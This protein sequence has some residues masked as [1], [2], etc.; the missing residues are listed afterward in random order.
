MD[1]SQA[2]TAEDFPEWVSQEFMRLNPDVE[3]VYEVITNAGASEKISAAILARQTP[4]LMKDVV[5]RKEWAE[6][7]LLEPIDDY[8]DP[9]DWEDWYELTLAKGRVNGKHY[10][11]P[12][13]NSATAWATC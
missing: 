11:F 4:D 13:N 9:E 3:V 12:W 6:R 7:G 1:P 5:W 10:I 8:V 2:P